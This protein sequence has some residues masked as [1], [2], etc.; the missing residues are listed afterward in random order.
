MSSHRKFHS[1]L[2]NHIF[3]SPAG[4]AFV[5]LLAAWLGVAP[6]SADTVSKSIDVYPL[7]V[8]NPRV[9]LVPTIDGGAKGKHFSLEEVVMLYPLHGHLGKAR[10][11]SLDV[12]VRSQRDRMAKW[13]LMLVGE[14]YALAIE[15][16]GAKDDRVMYLKVL[17]G[18]D[19]TWSIKVGKVIDRAD[20]H[21]AM[22]REW[23]QVSLQWG[24]G[25]ATLVTPDGN[26]HDV[27]L[28]ADFELQSIVVTA[29]LVDE[30]VLSTPRGRFGLDWESGYSAHV[31]VNDA[32]DQGGNTSAELLGF[33]SYVVSFDP[34][35]RHFPM[36]QVSNSTSKGR[37]VSVS[38]SL[39]GELGGQTQQWTQPLHVH[40]GDSIEVPIA[41]PQ[42]LESDVY[43][44]TAE[45]VASD[46]K[47][48]TLK[49]HF[50]VVPRRDEPAGPSKFGLHDANVR[51]FGFWPDPLPVDLAHHYLRWGYVIGPA[52]VKDD[53]QNYG[54]SPEIDPQ[55]WHW[56]A[57][58]DWSIASGRK[59]YVC[60]QSTPMADWQRVSI[61][62]GEMKKY[63]WGEVGGKPDT[64]LY[65][66]FVGA[67]AERYSGQ[68]GMWEVENE[69]N[70]HFPVS[71]YAD[72]V[73]VLQS[74]YE[75]IKSRDV[76]A[77]VYGI[78]GTGNFQPFL[79]YVLEHD[80]AT[81]MDGV[82]WHTYTSPKLPD[83][84]DLPGHLQEANVAINQSDESLTRIN[85]ETG[86]FVARRYKI[87][88]AIPAEL[89]AQR[90]AERNVSFI[91]NGWKG[92]VLDEW[93]A[94]TS[95]ITN[96]VYNF[97]AGAESFT[98]FGWN[99]DWPEDP[100]WLDK[101][102]WFALFTSS[103]EG[104]RGP[105]LT[106][107]AVATSMTQLEG[108]LLNDVD[109]TTIDGLRAVTFTK[110]NGGSVGVVWSVDGD[111]SVALQ[112]DSDTVDV[113]SAF[114]RGGSQPVEGGQVALTAG[115]LPIYVHSPS[116]TLKLLE[117]PFRMVKSEPADEQSGEVLVEL[118]N[119]YDQPWVGHIA[120]HDPAQASIDHD[121]AA[122]NLQPG[123]E[124]KLSFG[125]ALTDTSASVEQLELVA[126]S[127]AV[128]PVRTVVA[129]SRIPVRRIAVQ[130]S[131]PSDA[132]AFARSGSRATQTYP[133]DDRAHVVIGQPPAL[134]SLQRPEW[135]S[136]PEELSAQV[137][138]SVTDHGL[139]VG[140]NVTDTL[141][142]RPQDWPSIQGTSV[143]L[144]LD[145]R[146]Q[147]NG[148]GKSTYA[149][150]VAQFLLK[151]ALNAEEKVQVWSPQ[152][153]RLDG[154]EAEGGATETGYWLT[155]NIPWTL[156]QKKFTQAP[157]DFAF[158]VAVNGSFP[159]QPKRKSQLMLF[160]A[161]FNSR[162]ASAFGR[163]RIER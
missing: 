91:N 22:N 129:V 62:E 134:A 84:I 156:L 88:E 16:G 135:W 147:A 52:W 47:P 40:A 103:A 100:A 28:P 117:G 131:S 61:Y 44:L 154:I 21:T 3:H 142:K 46:L 74:V 87:D 136:G 77:R 49:K 161:S 158:D 1:M 35:S 13:V 10:T 132:E 23:Q 90:I 137:H 54:R 64:A 126:V 34:G 45:V 4:F 120:P 67:T 42:T 68:V 157:E 20:T 106:S 94:A 41:F 8:I 18:A 112:T 14:N 139:S 101:P 124:T 130:P 25:V 119:V 39:K 108:A 70:S 85:S 56:N 127:Q 27:Q 75:E 26:R 152:L 58:L 83:E 125:Y 122:F 113:R 160:G 65:R 116:P 104:E 110:A 53:G 12:A 118:I 76:N 111:R 99:P 144:F 148:L 121:A 50:M 55:E 105:S 36:L 140:L 69:P 128:P 138:L 82:S 96:V 2:S 93:R 63:P 115:P 73:E 57:R 79:E 162:D 98:F 71:E 81:F 24:G 37:D 38:L 145:T 43:H 133:L 163:F 143:E 29:D 11:G 32:V 33:D 9:P 153:D 102:T 7:A 155:C 109:V 92:D 48:V 80:G 72:Y 150:G 59:P 123:E 86:V 19:V 151:P 60:L 17:D 141:L 30:L 78:S 146:S 31:A 66:H 107:L 95:F 15:A 114:G 51:R 5:L 6:M 149:D 97:A 89:V 159:D